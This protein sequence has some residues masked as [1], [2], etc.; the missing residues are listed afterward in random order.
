MKNRSQLDISSIHDFFFAVCENC[1]EWERISILE[2]LA[3]KT[4]KQV[5]KMKFICRRDNNYSARVNSSNHSMFQFTIGR[6]GN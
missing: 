1:S 3:M 5:R 6:E 4:I 2:D